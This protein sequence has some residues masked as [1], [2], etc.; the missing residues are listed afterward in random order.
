MIT[1][2]K[3]KTFSIQGSML[4]GG[5]FGT[6]WSFFVNISGHTGRKGFVWK[7]EAGMPDFSW[8][9]IPKWGKCTK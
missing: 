8:Y 9:N 1:Y 4:G 2:L 7:A 5:I 6:F 3:K